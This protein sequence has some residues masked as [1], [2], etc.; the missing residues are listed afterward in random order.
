MVFAALG[1]GI[2]TF[3]VLGGVVVAIG[4]SV[5]LSEYAD[6][7][8]PSDY[9]MGRTKNAF[10]TMVSGI[11]GHK[12]YGNS[13][14]DVGVEKSWFPDSRVTGYSTR[15][16]IDTKTDLW[17]TSA[18][19]SAIPGYSSNLVGE[20]EKSEFDW[21]IEQKDLNKYK[22]AR[23]GPKFDATLEIYVENGEIKGTYH[24]PS[25]FDWDIKGSY[26]SNGN[27]DVEVDAPLTLGI[28]LKGK[29]EKQ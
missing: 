28:N 4:G 1:R 18:H 6:I 26:D 7:P 5:V 14:I 17:L 29:I 19:F 10:A 3:L 12:L 22:V 8:L 15:D 21:K 23:W 2:K 20:V 25:G 16:T 9:D 13:K 24:R 11:I 27:I